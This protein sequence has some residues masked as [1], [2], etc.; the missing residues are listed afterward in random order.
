MHFAH[1]FQNRFCFCSRTLKGKKLPTWEG[2]VLEQKQ[3]QLWN[4]WAKCNNLATCQIQDSLYQNK[5]PP[6]Y[7]LFNPL[8]FI[9]LSTPNQQDPV[10][11]SGTLRHNLDPF[12]QYRWWKRGEMRLQSLCHI[13]AVMPQFGPPSASPT[14]PIL[15]LVFLQVSRW[16]SHKL[17]VGGVKKNSNLN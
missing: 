4:Q 5:N 1:W 17:W 8:P 11:F 2:K 7:I 16:S 6:N 10:L 14:S 3:K 13:F 9:H 15:C 12:E